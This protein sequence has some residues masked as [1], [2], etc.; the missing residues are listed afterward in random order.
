MLDVGERLDPAHAAL[1]ARLS[2]TEP[3]EWQES[4]IAAVTNPRRSEESSGIWPFG[5]DFLFRDPTELFT[6]NE[7]PANIGLRP[8]FAV[9]GLSNGWGAS[10]LPYRAEDLLDWPVVARELSP[11]YAA[12]KTFLPIAAR[13]DALADVFPM[14]S[15]AADTSLQMT[16]QAQALLDRL[17]AKRHRLKLSG[18]HFGQARVA[19][20]NAECRR[21]GMCLY[22]CPYG[23]IFNSSALLDGLCKNEKFSGL[24]GVSQRYFQ[25]FWGFSWVIS[26]ERP[27]GSS[28]KTRSVFQGAVGA[29]CA[30]T[31]PSASTGPVRGRQDG[32]Q[33]GEPGVMSNWTAASSDCGRDDVHIR[34]ADLYRPNARFTPERQRY[35]VTYALWETRI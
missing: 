5:S 9:G 28:W 7:P 13:P 4:D 35:Q 12:L 22:G 8:S 29:F 20:S 6:N 16:S 18:V 10:I 34:T 3:D 26:W 30:S 11:H 14:L 1:R 33:G 19:V 32:S 15:V 21:C 25:A 2:G 31:A 27:C 23:V 17:E 24:S